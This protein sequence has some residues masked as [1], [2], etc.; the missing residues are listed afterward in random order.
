LNKT[1]QDLKTEQETKKK[2]QRETNLELEKLGK[3]SAGIDARVINRL[4]E[5][6]ERISGI[7]D[8]IKNIDTAVKNA[9]CKKLLTKTSRKSRT[10]LE[11]KT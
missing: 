5:I 6:E 7:K 11:D 3:R 9:K 8:T 10:Q 4:Q 1:I 2:S